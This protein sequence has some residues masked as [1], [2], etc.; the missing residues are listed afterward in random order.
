MINKFKL[1]ETF[2]ARMMDKSDFFI[3]KEFT[4][5]EKITADSS[6]EKQTEEASNTPQDSTDKHTLNHTSH[7]Q[8]QNPH[9]PPVGK[10]HSPSQ[11]ICYAVKQG[12]INLKETKSYRACFQSGQSKTN[13]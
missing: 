7:Q 5:A 8:Q 4:Q 9:A 10:A 11:T 3:Y 6:Q 12:S 1:G 13:R 2:A